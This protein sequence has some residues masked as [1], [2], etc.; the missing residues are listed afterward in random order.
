MRRLKSYSRTSLRFISIGG[1][2]VLHSHQQLRSLVLKRLQR[3]DVANLFSTP[4]E[5]AGKHEFIWYT[6][7]PGTITGFEALPSDQRQRREAELQSA[8]DVLRGLAGQLRAEAGADRRSLEA[9]IL[10]AATTVPDDSCKFMVGNQPVLAAWGSS[11][12]ASS[13]ANVDVVWTAQASEPPS[14]QPSQSK[15][16][17][18]DTPPGGAAGNAAE[19]GATASARA[20]SFTRLRHA[21][22]LL[23]VLAGMLLVAVAHLFG[24]LNG[25]LNFAGLFLSFSTPSA[26]VEIDKDAGLRGDVADLEKQ[27][28]SRLDTCPAPSTREGS[29]APSLPMPHQPIEE[30]EALPPAPTREAAPAPSLPIPPPALEKNDAPSVQVTRDDET[31]PS[32]S[33]PPQALEKKDTSFLSGCWNAPEVSVVMNAGSPDEESTLAEAVLCF[34]AGGKTGKRTIRN[35]KISCEGPLSANLTEKSV[36]IMAPPMRCTGGPPFFSQATI[37]CVAEG[38]QT[39]CKVTQPGHSDPIDITFTKRDEK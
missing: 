29:T 14:I 39:L 17:V 38:S 19:I 8:L 23:P 13:R 24:P 26:G 34:D 15:A 36:T 16:P 35:S 22:W 5:D 21:A 28:L 12:A 7:L 25:G 11:L 2:R 10:E 27:L 1:Q 37:I 3:P 30:K 9:E 6:S 18:P 33:I 4:E 20:G 32:L 31:G